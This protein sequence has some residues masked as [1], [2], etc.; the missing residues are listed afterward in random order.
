MGNI[1]KWTPIFGIDKNEG[2]RLP[3]DLV[4]VFT[5]KPLI[6]AVGK[7]VNLS[8][9][10]H[11]VFIGICRNLAKGPIKFQYIERFSPNRTILRT[12]S[13]KEV[14]NLLTTYFKDQPQQNK[15]YIL[16]QLA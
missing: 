14:I 15:T 3:T 12:F 7:G 2:K 16:M 6:I 11:E 13:R 10:P 1:T 4:E 8:G 5:D 9:T